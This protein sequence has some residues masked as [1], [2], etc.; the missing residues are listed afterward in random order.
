LTTATE[1]AAKAPRPAPNDEACNT[2][3]DGKEDRKNS[4]TPL[5]QPTNTDADAG[6]R[7]TTREAAPEGTGEREPEKPNVE[8]LEKIFGSD[9]NNLIS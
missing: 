1:R 7:D 5:A 6:T 4:S 9:I 3:A 2:V 8:N